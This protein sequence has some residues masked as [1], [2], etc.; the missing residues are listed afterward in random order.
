[1]ARRSASLLSTGTFDSFPPPSLLR[2]LAHVAVGAADFAFLDLGL[3][4]LP[5][6]APSNHVRNVVFLGASDVI[7]CENDRILVAAIDAGMVVQVI[8]NL[9]SHIVTMLIVPF[10]CLFPVRLTVAFVMAPCVLGPTRATQRCSSA[11]CS[12]L[13]V[14][15][16]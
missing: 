7:E 14:K 13:E 6:S 15:V 8:K 11:L 2:C 3:D 5:P 1:M 9:T 12:G 16:P 10:A 4:G